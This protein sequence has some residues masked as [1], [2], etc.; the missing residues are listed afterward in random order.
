M[1]FEEP[2]KFDSISIFVSVKPE[3][4]TVSIK[5]F[6]EDLRTDCA[7][8]AESLYPDNVKQGVKHTLDE[9]VRALDKA[10]D[11]FGLS[12]L[13]SIYDPLREGILGLFGGKEANE[14]INESEND[15][16][17]QQ[18]HF[19]DES[20]KE[21]TKEDSRQYGCDLPVFECEQDQVVP[22]WQTN[23]LD[24]CGMNVYFPVPS[25]D[26][27]PGA[28]PM[29]P[30]TLVESCTSPVDPAS[31]E[32]P[33]NAVDTIS[34]ALEPGQSTLDRW[35]KKHEKISMINVKETDPLLPQNE[36]QW[37]PAQVL[38]LLNGFHCDEECVPAKTINLAVS[39][40]TN[41]QVHHQVQVGTFYKSCGVGTHYSPNA[42]WTSSLF[43][44]EKPFSEL[45][46]NKNEVSTQ[47]DAKQDSNSTLLPANLEENEMD[48]EIVEIADIENPKGGKL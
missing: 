34:S 11:V 5:T 18:V 44:I 37:G 32:S 21:K 1:Q 23:E 13:E 22:D 4:P 41:H 27:L 48:F 25:S 6:V 19:N 14:Q 26:D 38:Q 31:V 15:L 20:L 17:I 12:L 29:T 3:V 36:I 42:D 35:I 7:R 39:N 33:V 10:N 40:R 8:M 46:L 28:F 2:S 43:K 9:F 24:S 47:F 30:I 16:N 45:S